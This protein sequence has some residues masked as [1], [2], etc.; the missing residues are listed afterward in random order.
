[1]LECVLEW[2]KHDAKARV[3]RLETLLPLVRYG[4]LERRPQALQREFKLLHGVSEEL[5]RFLF[6][7]AWGDE[8]KYERPRVGHA[9][10]RITGAGY[11]GVNGFWGIDPG[12]PE[13]NGRAVYK[14]LKPDGTFYTPGALKSGSHALCWKEMLEGN[15]LCWKWMFFN[16]GEGRNDWPY[17]NVGDNPRPP[18]TGWTQYDRMGV[19]PKPALMWL[20]SA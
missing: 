18:A 16:C 11:D 6:T 2:A 4:R 20:D 15:A 3:A 5:T 1:M 9:L 7:L 19:N 10:I 13:R 17:C 8:P 14:K 12:V